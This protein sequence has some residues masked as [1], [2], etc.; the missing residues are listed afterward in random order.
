MTSETD[1]YRRLQEHLD[2]MPIGYPATKS[3]VEISLLKTIFTPEE[4]GVTTHLNRPRWRL[5]RKRS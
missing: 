2:R 1:A 4:A 3:G 5:A